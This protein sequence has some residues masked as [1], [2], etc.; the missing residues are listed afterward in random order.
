M[1]KAFDNIGVACTDLDR[2]IGFYEQIG[3]EKEYEIE[4]GIRGAAMRSGDAVLYLFQ[5]RATGEVGRDDTLE[6]N[7]PGLD[8]ISFLVDDCD[9]A[10]ADLAAKGVGFDSDPADQ[11][12]GARLAGF[13][14]PDGNNLYLLQYLSS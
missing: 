6:N 11:D 8:H 5:T 2:S 14:D 4:T 12:W 7:P 1:L 3:F 10:H 9:A 13:K